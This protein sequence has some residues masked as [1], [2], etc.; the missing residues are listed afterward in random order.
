MAPKIGE[1]LFFYLGDKGFAIGFIGEVTVFIYFC[2]IKYY[3]AN[4]F[5]LKLCKI[6]LGM[7]V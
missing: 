4:R 7:F 2:V 1:L 6:F 5:L 3:S